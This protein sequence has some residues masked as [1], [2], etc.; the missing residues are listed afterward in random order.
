MT[1][2]N[3]EPRN[4]YATG[5]QGQN[6]Q[7]SQYPQYQRNPQNQGYPQY[8]QNPYQQHQPGYPGYPGY[9]ARPNMAGIQMAQT[10]MVLGIL[11]IFFFG[12]I[13][14]PLAIAKANRAER[15]F[16]TP[17][18]AG[19]VTG[20]IGLILSLCWVAYVGFMIIVAVSVPSVSTPQGF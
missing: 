1:T 16:N 8:Q 13:L 10:S 12:I 7:Y 18:S 2:P 11:S 20:W 17:A 19:K 15:E 14:G 6:S 3:N 5:Q 9:P 4:P